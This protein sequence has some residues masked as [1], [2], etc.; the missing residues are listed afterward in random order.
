MPVDKGNNKVEELNEL[1]KKTTQID[2]LINK[3]NSGKNAWEAGRLL[4]DIK[5]NNEYKAKNYKNFGVYTNND[6]R[7][8]ETKALSYINIYLF[9]DEDKISPLV[10]VTH[11]AYLAKKDHDIRDSILGILKKKDE[12]VIKKFT[13]AKNTQQNTLFGVEQPNIEKEEKLQIR[14]DYDK[15][16]ITVTANLLETAKDTG[17]SITSELAEEAFEISTEVNY[18]DFNKIKLPNAVGETIKS[19][20]LQDIERL[21]RSEPTNELGLVGLFCTMFHTLKDLEFIYGRKT[22]KFNVINYIREEFPD[23]EI[24][25]S[26]PKS[27]IKSTLRVEF[28]FRSS[29]YL[30]HEHNKSEKECNLI[31]AWEYNLTNKQ[32]EKFGKVL[33][34]I[35]SVK[36]ILETGKINLF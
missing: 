29:N 2:K 31:I 6:L 5:N 18:R 4:Y 9:Y 11:L 17:H 19:I 12:K 13:K 34:P 3:N 8:S 10:L 7:I 15:D 36:N 1:S 25:F 30:L 28:E 24:E 22:L 16:I 21:Y 35:I 26:V 20:H 33:P 27:K 23:A 14:P 32:I